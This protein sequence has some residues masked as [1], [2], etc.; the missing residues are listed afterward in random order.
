MYYE[1]ISRYNEALVVTNIIKSL[2]LNSFL[3]TSK[4]NDYCSIFVKIANYSY[5]N[6]NVT[7]EISSLV[8]RGVYFLTD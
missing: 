6:S 3:T 5:C 2:C 7:I 4:W 1:I 8:D